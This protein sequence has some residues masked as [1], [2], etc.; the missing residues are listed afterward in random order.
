MFKSHSLGLALVPVLFLYTATFNVSKPADNID[1]KAK[2]FHNF[3]LQKHYKDLYEVH[4]EKI[5]GIDVSH[6]QSHIDWDEV[7]HIKDSIEV[8]FVFARATFGSDKKD[9]HFDRNWKMATEKKMLK[10]AYH[11]Y[12]PMQNPILQAQHFVK[13]VTLE[14]GDLPPVLDIESKYRRQ[15]PASLRANLKKWL[16]YVENHYGVKPIIY[17][18]DGFYKS[19]LNTGEFDEYPLWIANYNQVTMPRNSRW[20]LWQFSEK[21]KAT[22]IKT[23]VDLNVF[24]GSL[25]DLK[26]LAITKKPE[27]FTDSLPARE[28]VTKIELQSRPLV[29]DIKL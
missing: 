3:S 17:T 6:H 26:K 25:E 8:S 28:P 14:E 24:N 29:M 18:N 22:G 12:R 4:S 7:S 9:L 1:F 20:I 27:V 5:F 2:T 15:K 10:G 19:Y 23:N 16:N 21:G 11:F 13:H